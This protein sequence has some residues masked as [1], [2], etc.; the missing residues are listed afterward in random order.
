MSDGKLNYGMVSILHMVRLDKPDK[1][2][3]SQTQI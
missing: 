1:D 2:W 3:K